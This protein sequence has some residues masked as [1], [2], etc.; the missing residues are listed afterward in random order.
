[1]ELFNIIAHLRGDARIA[2]LAEEIAERS[3]EGVR[4]RVAARLPALGIAE[5]RGYIR[6]RS[7][8]VVRPLADATVKSAGDVKPA[9]RPQ[10]IEKATEEVVRRLVWEEMGRRRHA[11]PARRAA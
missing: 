5:A 10:L 8:A 9:W 1:M 2:D 11:A 3:L 6:S 7:A 4:A